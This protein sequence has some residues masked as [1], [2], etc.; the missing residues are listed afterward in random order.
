MKPVLQALVLAEK[1][2]EDKTGKKIIAGTF[3]AVFYKRI[4]DL[5][6]E[7]ELPSGKTQRLVPGGL[8]GGS[9]WAYI[10]VTDAL[11]GTELTLQFVNLTRNIVLLETKIVIQSQDRLNAVEIIAPLPPLPIS[12][13]GTYAFEVVCEG[14]IL[15]S[16]R[17]IAKELPNAED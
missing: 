4:A 10:S 14:Q 13:D 6:Q 8:H 9:P 16:H 5:V 11:D 12:E 1:V 3:D 7:R 15:G 17:I 2:Y